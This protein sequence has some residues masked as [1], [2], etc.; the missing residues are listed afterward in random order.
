M[1]GSLNSMVLYNFQNFTHVI[2]YNPIT[3]VYVSHSA[4]SASLRPHGL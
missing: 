1:K 3:R 2:S 4:V